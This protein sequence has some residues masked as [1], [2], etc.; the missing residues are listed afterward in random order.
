M[1]NNDVRLQME[2]HG[3]VTNRK[4]VPNI[5]LKF[6]EVMADV[7]KMKAPEKEAAKPRKPSRKMPLTEH[8]SKD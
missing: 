6:E 2:K 4:L 8:R 7:L 5:P 1:K 3:V